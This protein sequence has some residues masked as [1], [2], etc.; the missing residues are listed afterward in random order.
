[1]TTRDPLAVSPISTATAPRYEWGSGCEG[2]HLLAAPSLSVIQEQ[3]PAGTS[4]VRHIHDQA[5]QFFFVIGGALIIE[6]DGVSHTLLEG[7]GLRVPPGTAHRVFNHTSSAAQF[8]VVS[9]P[10][11]HGDRRAALIPGTK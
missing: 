8:L 3:M 2:W 4:E 1:M 5:Q 9:Q 11:S 7:D 10:P 6:V